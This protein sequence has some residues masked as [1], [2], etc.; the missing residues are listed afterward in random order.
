MHPSGE[1]YVGALELESGRWLNGLFVT[2]AWTSPLVSQNWTMHAV[3]LGFMMLAS[4]LLS[5]RLTGPMRRFAEAA[6]DVGRGRRALLP[7]GGPSEVRRT[8]E[9]FDAMQRRI[10]ALVDDRTHLLAAIGHDLRTPLTS[11]RLRA[12]LVEEPPLRARLLG[13]LDRLEAI[14]ESALDLV[15]GL[16]EE[17]PVRIGLHELLGELVANYRD[18]GHDVSLAPASSAIDAACRPVMLRRALVNLIDNALRHGGGTAMLSLRRDETGGIEIRVRDRG[19]GIDPARLQDAFE[20]F[21]RLDG[22]RTRATGGSGLGLTLA[23]SVAR[24]H[25]GDVTLGAGD[26]GPGLV[27]ALHFP[28][29]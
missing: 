23:R 26:D 6:T 28:D 13:D 17:P 19:E 25:G 27:A 2:P 7:A 5:R 22:A 20:P 1:G 16:A 24:R 21:R 3:T 29:D 15:R 14:T 4:V 10:H 12:H 18:A 9:A 11:A 8:A